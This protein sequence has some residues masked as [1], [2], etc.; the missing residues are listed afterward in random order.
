MSSVNSVDEFYTKTII[1]PEVVAVE[2]VVLVLEHFYG[3]G[4][5]IFSI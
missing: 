4:F 3:I 5:S 1:A 2:G